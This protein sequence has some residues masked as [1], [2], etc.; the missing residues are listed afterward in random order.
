[1]KDLIIL[2]RTDQTAKLELVK[3]FEPLIY[4][5]IKM[6]IHDINFTQDALQEGYVTILKCINLY[7][8]DSEC[9]FPGYVKTALINNLRKFS[10]NHQHTLSLDEECCDEGGTLLDTLPSDDIIEDYY[11]QSQLSHELKKT[12]MALPE[13]EKEL[14]ISIY[15]KQIKIMQLS[16]GTRSGYVRLQRKRDKALSMLRDGLKKMGYV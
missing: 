5:C 12:L 4:K 6:Y 3:R 9:G 1:M 7:N 13:D 8:L 14:I 11:I 10:K 2:A 15:F 16:N